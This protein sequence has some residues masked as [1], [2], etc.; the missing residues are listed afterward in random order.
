MT[1]AIAVLLCLSVALAGALGGA[2]LAML[3]LGLIHAGHR[4]AWRARQ[5]R[6]GALL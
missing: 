1:A 2:S 4:I 3:L 6:P 5:R